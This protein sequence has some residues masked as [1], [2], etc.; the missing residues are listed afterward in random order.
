MILSQTI[1]IYG[2]PAFELRQVSTG[3]PPAYLIS[4]K[5][6]L[7]HRARNSSPRVERMRPAWSA[8][9]LYVR[10]LPAML[11][12]STVRA[13]FAFSPEWQSIFVA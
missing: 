5:A 12:F 6:L 10:S 2:P 7:H 4:N 9:D 11:S 8:E 3:T 1:F 13:A